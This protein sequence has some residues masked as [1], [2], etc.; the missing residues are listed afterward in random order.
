MKSETRTE[1]MAIPIVAIVVISDR[2]VVIDEHRPSAH[3]VVGVVSL[4]SSLEPQ[5][6]ATS[7]HTATTMTKARRLD[8]GVSLGD[9][10]GP[11]VSR[12]TGDARAG[13]RS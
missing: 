11:C 12:A 9:W 5:P 10:I 7:A 1:L 4:E 13:I 6:A 2:Q 8:I 3:S